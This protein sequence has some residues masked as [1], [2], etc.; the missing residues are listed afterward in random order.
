M[1]LYFSGTGNSLAIAR[2][3]AERLNE[4]VMSLYEAARLDLTQEK[5]V[6]LV[7]PTYNLTA[8]KAVRDLV[9]QLHVSPDAYV[10]I[11]I[12]CGA[13]TNN[14]IWAVR[15]L[16]RK[17]GV[18]VNYCHKIRVP[19]S[20]A[21]AFGRNPNDQVWK[22]EKYASRLQNIGDELVAQKKTLHFAGF[23]PFG[24]LMSLPRLERKIGNMTQPH[25]DEQKCI[26]C[27]ICAKV[28]PQENIVLTAEKAT[29]AD[30]CTWC[31]SCVHFCPQQAVQLNG[32][33]ITKEFQYHHPQV[34][35]KDMIKR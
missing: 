28:C 25:V 4:R 12:T 20:S 16:L 14:A 30:K 9:P 27:G 2:Q 6:G 17:Q 31:L 24:W 1:I 18:R 3:L 15:R 22:F 26:G 5:Q 21:L 13:Q 7:F 11:V 35:L 23:D 10:W 19:D 29:I 33:Q 34:K 8:P 32:R